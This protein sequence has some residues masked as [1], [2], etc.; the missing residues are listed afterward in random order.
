MN[1]FADNTD[2]YVGTLTADEIVYAGGKMYTSNRDYYLI[3]D[4]QESH[5]L[6]FSSLSL[7]DRFDLFKLDDTYFYVTARDYSLQESSVEYADFRPAITLATGIK[8]SS[9]D[10]TISNPYKI[11][12]N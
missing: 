10:G 12:E 1:K 8:I 3:N 9:G 7:Y 6:S 5:L 11:L 4:Y 2:M